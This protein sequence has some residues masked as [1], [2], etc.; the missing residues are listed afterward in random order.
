MR[1]L[2]ILCLAVGLALASSEQ[3]VGPSPVLRGPTPNPRSGVSPSTP[4]MF[5]D[6]TD[7]LSYDD[8]VPTQSYY[9]FV[10]GNGWGM[11]FIPPSD[12][13]TLA[14]ALIYPSAM[15]PSNQA[16]VMAFTDDGPGGSPGT[17]IFADTVD[18]TPDQWNLVPISVPI[19]A[20][21]F[22]VFYIQA[23]DSAGGPS[24]GID[25]SSNAPQHRKWNLTAG[26]FA[27]DATP[28]D[29]LIRAVL[30]WTPQ[31]T[32]ASAFRFAN[33]V[34]NDTVPNINFTIRAM[35]RNLGTDA[36]PIGTPVRLAVSGP[37]GYTFDDTMATTAAL[38]HGATRQIN[39]TPA[40]H[41]PDEPGN[42]NIK[43]WTDAAGEK[44]PADDTISWDLS[45]AK[46]VQYVTESK[47]W[48][49]SPAG[50]DKA[51][52]FDP[53]DFSMQYPVALQRVRA[54]FYLH[55]QIPWPDSSFE[56]LVYGEDGSTL[57]YESEILEAP[58]GTPGAPIAYTFDPP[59][60]ISSGTF[61]VAVS[62]ISGNGRPT[63]ISDS[64]ASVGHSYSGSAGDWTLNA[65]AQG[66]EWFISAAAVGN[67]GVEEKGFE[68]GLRNPSLQITNFPNPVGDQVTLKWQVP[69]SMPISVNLYDATGRMV[70]NLYSA[71]DKAR[72][73]TLTMDTRSL[74]AG[75][76]LARLETA[77]GSATRKLV[78]DR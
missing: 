59:V 31:D 9:W 64:C 74:A 40:W 73:G 57:L 41:I 62:S 44:Y 63:L 45:C 56:F 66:G 26:T 55:S 46:W 20:S 53:A 22:Y 75:I 67:Y 8:G 71:N 49:I 52:L 50:P 76:Y 42:Y 61:Y 15:G 6:A 17:K 38:A 34:I 68:P 37:D 69:S 5:L 58:A 78:I 16:V 33:V 70:R 28:G 54:E 13:V 72:V 60:I 51:T 1:K 3:W 24:F 65:G 21:N 35:I 29:W 4:A 7:T 36:L 77:K 32:N 27:E 43:V 14:G 12:N 10:A 48:W 2:V 19:V 18:V 23:H 39:F 25:A 11:K 30:D 47:L